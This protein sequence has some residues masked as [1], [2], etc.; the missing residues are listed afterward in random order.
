MPDASRSTTAHA[1]PA[2]SVL[3]ARAGGA[4]DRLPDCGRDGHYV[5]DIAVGFWSR[6]VSPVRDLTRISKRRQVK[7]SRCPCGA[8]VVGL[9]IV[10][11][12]LVSEKARWMRV[13]DLYLSLT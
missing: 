12:I 1:G 4:A 8:S 11:M 13:D 9:G 7:S 2:N 10:V 5:R 3:Q 6:L